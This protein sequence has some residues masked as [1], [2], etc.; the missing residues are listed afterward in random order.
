VLSAVDT[1]SILLTKF[2]SAVN[3]RNRPG[4]SPPGRRGEHRER[5]PP[6]PGA[7]ATDL[8]LVQA[9]ADKA[10]TGLK[11]ELALPAEDGRRRRP[12]AGPALRL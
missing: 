5:D 7:P 12:P 1:N 10:V 2:T 11:W 3:D 6:G 9:E 8:M 4:L